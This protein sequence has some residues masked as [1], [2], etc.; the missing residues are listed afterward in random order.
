[1]EE[2]KLKKQPPGSRGLA[3]GWGIW[4]KKGIDQCQE[5]HHPRERGYGRTVTEKRKKEGKGGEVFL[6]KG[7][8]T[9]FGGLVL[10]GVDRTRARDGTDRGTLMGTCFGYP[11]GV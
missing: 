8:G 4:E 7:F 5:G 11:G 10:G 9:P 6:G 1:V 3:R 2:E